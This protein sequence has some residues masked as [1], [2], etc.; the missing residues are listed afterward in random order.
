MYIYFEDLL[1]LLFFLDNFFQIL[2]ADLE[3]D[4]F[5]KLFWYHQVFQKADG[6]V[7]E[8]VQVDVF[9]FLPFEDKQ[10]Y[11]FVKVQHSF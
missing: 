7:F 3:V 8:A 9:V 10:P 4:S 1:L 2:V 5:H 11:L 6:F